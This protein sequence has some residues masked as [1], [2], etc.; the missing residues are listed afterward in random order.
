MTAETL[1]QAIFDLMADRDGLLERLK[2]APPANG[3]QAV[4]RLI[5]EIQQK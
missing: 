2:N 5:E 3:T 4:L 1:T